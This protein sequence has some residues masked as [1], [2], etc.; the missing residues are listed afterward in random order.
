M[1]ALNDE[2][3]DFNLVLLDLYMPEMDGFE[4]AWSLIG[5]IPHL[6]W[7]VL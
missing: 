3:N 6:S 2:N 1:D 5:P 7:I 4:V